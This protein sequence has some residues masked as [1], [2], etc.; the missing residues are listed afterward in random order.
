METIRKN[1]WHFDPKFL[2]SLKNFAKRKFLLLHVL[3]STNTGLFSP[4]VHKKKQKKKKKKRSFMPVFVVNSF[5]ACRI[6]ENFLVYAHSQRR[7][8]MKQA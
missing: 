2:K 3:V 7:I 8:S 1:I 6:S 5:E 4:H